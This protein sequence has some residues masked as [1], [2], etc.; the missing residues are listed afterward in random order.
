MINLS[1]GYKNGFCVAESLDGN[2]YEFYRQVPL[3]S[4]FNKSQYSV[5]NEY[6]DEITRRAMND[7][8]LRDSVTDFIR[9]LKTEIVQVLLAIPPYNIVEAEKKAADIERYLREDRSRRPRNDHVSPSSDDQRP[10][11]STQPLENQL[12]HLIQC[13]ETS[14]KLN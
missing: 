6:S 4:S 14:G 12:Q 3:Q 5:T 7:R 10:I 13:Q 11:I 2:R 1:I 9:G 8:I